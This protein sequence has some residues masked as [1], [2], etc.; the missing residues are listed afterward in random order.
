MESGV[1]TKVKFNKVVQCYNYDLTADELAWKKQV[2]EE[3]KE[4]HANNV[5]WCKSV[6]AAK[7]AAKAAAKS[8]EK[9]T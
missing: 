5:E 8:F 7:A 2:N 6:K 9:L 3:F 4:M 1:M